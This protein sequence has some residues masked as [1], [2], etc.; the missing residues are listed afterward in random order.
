MKRENLVQIKRIANKEQE[1]KEY[2]EMGMAEWERAN[3][4]LVGNYVLS[5]REDMPEGTLTTLF[6]NATVFVALGNPLRLYKNDGVQVWVDE[7]GQMW[8]DSKV[9]L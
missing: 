6:T 3:V 1:Q 5:D 4:S 8:V 2:E 7:E 9:V